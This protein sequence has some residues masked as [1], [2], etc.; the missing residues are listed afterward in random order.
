MPLSNLTGK[1]K[2]SKKEQKKSRY[3]ILGFDRLCLSK[4]WKERK[5]NNLTI[6]E[7]EEGEFA[8]RM[9]LLGWN[10]CSHRLAIFN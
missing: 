2:E 1:I 6:N 3:F 7:T 10:N 9:E 5:N 4:L 8:G